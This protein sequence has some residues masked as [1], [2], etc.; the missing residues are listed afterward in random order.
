MLLSSDLREAM[1]AA[2]QKTVPQF[3]D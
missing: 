3:R 1:S 2:M